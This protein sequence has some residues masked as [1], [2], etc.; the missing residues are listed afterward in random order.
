[1][2]E[3]PNAHEM[4]AIKPAESIEAGRG[5]YGVSPDQLKLFPEEQKR[6][7]ADAIRAVDSLQTRWGKV[8]VL[9]N[10]IPTEF[11]EK[12]EVDLRY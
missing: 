1:M 10:R 5:N 12:G 7:F 9:G 3:N 2:I 11:N 8:T 4:S 6:A